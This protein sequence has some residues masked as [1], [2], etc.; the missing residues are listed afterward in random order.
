MISTRIRTLVRQ[1]WAGLIALFLVL[2]GGS[3]W[4]LDGS[5]TVFSDDIVNGEVKEADVGQGAVASA[6]IKNDSVLPADVAPNSLT[7]G[8][9]LDGTLTGVDVKDNSL[10]GADIDESTLSGIGGGGPAGGDLTGTYPDPLIRQNAVGGGKV[11]NDSLTGDDVNESTLGQVPSAL[12]GGF[13]RTGTLSGTCNPESETFVTCASVNLDLPT[14]TRVLVLGRITAAHGKSDF[15]NGT[16]AL[17]TAPPGGPVPN[18]VV[19]K[20]LDADEYTDDIPLV[21]ITD[22]LPAGPTLFALDCNE[23]STGDPINYTRASVTAVALS[24][25]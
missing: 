2:S 11:A 12:L 25:S 5:N 13:G 17:A 18:T 8:R 15:S 19:F 20:M 4:A 22:V 10:K 9:I 7:T 14:P 16:C 6:E 24:P 21:G 23:D 3:A 1:Q